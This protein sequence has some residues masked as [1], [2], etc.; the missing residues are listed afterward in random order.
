MR[1]CEWSAVASEKKNKL[2]AISIGTLHR[3]YPGNDLSL[4]WA[5]VAKDKGRENKT[6]DEPEYIML[7]GPLLSAVRAELIGAVVWSPHVPVPL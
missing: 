5:N 1:S 6:R 4:V 3:A 7:W 2:F